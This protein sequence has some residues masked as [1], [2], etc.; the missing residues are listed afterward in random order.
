MKNIKISDCE[1]ISRTNSIK[2][3]TE[4]TF[5]ISDIQI[6]NC[7]LFLP[8]LY[9]YTVSAIAIEAVDGSKVSNVTAENITVNNCS[10]PIF[11]RLGNRNRASEV[12][13]QSA[14]AIER[15]QKAEKGFS[16][17][18]DRFDFKSAIENITIKNLTADD[19]EM[20][21]MICGF[22]QK[23]VTKRVKNEIGRA[24]V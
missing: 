23:G 10:C 5:D 22:T 11:I 4:T 18:K 21:I 6:E 2:I 20:P 14:N 19:A 16:A 12:T 17:D 15:G 7:R 3:G 1:I 8:D 13:A 24:H 9:P